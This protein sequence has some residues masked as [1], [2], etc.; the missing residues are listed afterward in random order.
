M[1]SRAPWGLGSHTEG[2]RHRPIPR[3]SLA[4]TVAG[5]PVG[6]QPVARGAD[7]VVAAQA[8]PALMLALV[9]HLA[10]VEVCRVRGVRAS[11]EASVPFSARCPGAAWFLPPPPS[12]DKPMET[13]ANGGAN[14]T[15]NR[16]ATGTGAA[17]WGHSG[18]QTLCKALPRFT[19]TSTSAVPLGE[20]RGAGLG[21]GTQPC[22]LRHAA[23]GELSVERPSPRAAAQPQPA[24]E[25]IL[26]VAA[27]RAPALC[28]CRATLPTW[29]QGSAGG[30]QALVGA[31]QVAALKG[32][33][34]RKLQ[35]LVY[36]WW[37]RDEQLQLGKE[38]EAGAE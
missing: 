7:T 29:Q 26:G 22:S 5:L 13:L 4:L 19:L 9:L 33:R 30:T 20:A 12:T 14:R 35:A 28:L 2:L 8:V 17:F 27:H 31:P 6:H 24:Q 10:L 25:G 34:W 21:L 16:A 3:A 18:L 1:T 11:R 38:T 23:Q 32:T 37:R 15:G 36:V